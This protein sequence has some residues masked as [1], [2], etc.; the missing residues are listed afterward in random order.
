MGFLESYAPQLRS[1]LRIVI[2]LMILQYGMSKI[3]HIPYVAMFA[4]LPPL[5]IAAGTIELVGGVLILF[6]VYTR[7][8]A[9]IL[10]GEMAFAYWLG[11]VGGTGKLL[12]ILN[13]GG[14][15]VIFCFVFLYLAAA[16]PGPWSFD[17]K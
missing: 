15:A 5:I 3:F 7:I 2:G 14:L 13:H 10:S 16:G 8:V 6:G 12:P 9:F 11:H 4:H 17:G 1:V